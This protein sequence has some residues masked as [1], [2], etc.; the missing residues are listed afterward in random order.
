MQ[1]KQYPK[2]NGLKEER[3]FTYEEIQRGEQ[4]LYTDITCPHCDKIQSLCAT[5]YV[6]GPCIKCGE[7]TNGS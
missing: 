2:H 6:G 1:L 3:G 5:G 7:L 4:W